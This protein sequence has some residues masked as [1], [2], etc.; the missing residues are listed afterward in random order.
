MKEFI[1]SII[2]ELS[3][4]KIKKIIAIYPGRFQPMGRHHVMT[5]NWLQKKFSPQNTYIATSDKVELPKSPFNFAEKKK[6]MNSYGIK[7]ISKEPVPYIANNLLKKYNPET[8]AVVYMVGEKDMKE[9]PRFKIGKKKNGDDSYYQMYDTNKDNLVGYNKHAYLIIAPHVSFDIPGYGEMSGTAIRSA[10][11]DKEKSTQDKLKLFAG[12]FGHTKKDIYD[13]VINKMEKLNEILGDFIYSINYGSL[14]ENKYNVDKKTT[15][16]IIDYIIGEERIPINHQLKLMTEMLFSYYI[17]NHNENLSFGALKLIENYQSSL[18]NEVSLKTYVDEI[19]KVRDGVKSKLSPWNNFDYVRM[20][21]SNALRMAVTNNFISNATRLKL[22]KHNRK[23]TDLNSDWVSVVVDGIDILLSSKLNEYKNSRRQLLDNKNDN[24]SHNKILLTC[25]GA[26]GHM[27]HPFDDNDLTFGDLK[28]LIR[29]SLTGEL[30]VEDV[31]EK[32]DGQNIMVTWKDG[33]IKAS[34]NKTQI[35]NPISIAEISKMFAGR[36]DIHDAFVYAMVDLNSAVSKLSERER[37]EIFD[38][39]KN[40]MNLEI[41]YPATKNVIDYDKQLLQFHGALIYDDNG[42]VIGEV[43]KS[44]QKLAAMIQK[45]NQAVQKHFTIIPPAVIKINKSINFSAN[46]NKFLD[47]VTKL[48][49]RFSLND[50]DTVSLYHQRHWEELINKKAM[51]LKYAIPNNVLMGLVKRWAFFDKSYDLRNMKKDITSDIFLEWVIKFDKEDHTKEWKQTIT[52]FENIFLELG[53]EVLQNAEGFISISPDKTIADIRM[54]LAK[55]IRDIRNSGDLNSLEKLN[56][57]LKRIQ[58]IGGFKKIVPS[59]GI[60]I[61]FKGR[62]LKYT[63]I[64]APINNILGITK[65]S[66]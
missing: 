16:D 38:N 31:V 2:Q 64:F 39:G 45:I 46:Q 17:N 34:R 5:F 40:F 35:K 50:T 37:N 25:G 59:E 61:K 19:R 29:N 41:I 15:S 24:I 30:S 56:I 58:A 22:N 51:Q 33:K 13:L 6:I 63:G 52:P 57:Q 66:R 49:N 12:I 43:P 11:G 62:T 20:I 8:T 36:G 65:Y 27:S 9:D 26:Y 23:L 3:G 14:I 1:K 7:N 44:G 55:V 48:Q 54:Q 32:T 28:E 60:V 42:N 21:Y 10:F 53:A 18:I 4:N 47:S